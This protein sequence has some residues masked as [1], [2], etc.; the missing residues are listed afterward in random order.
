MLGNRLY[1]VRSNAKKITNLEA[2]GTGTKLV[3]V[4]AATRRP[5]GENSVGIGSGKR[6]NICTSGLGFYS[7]WQKQQRKNVLHR[8]TMLAV[9]QRTD[10]LCE[11]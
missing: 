1:C 7:F 8:W 6:A 2:R 11:T 3:A 10:M 4:E 9:E 5:F